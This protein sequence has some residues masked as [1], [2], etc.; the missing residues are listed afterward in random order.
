MI[1]SPRRRRL[2]VDTMA[3]RSLLETCKAWN[4][5]LGPQKDRMVAHDDLAIAERNITQDIATHT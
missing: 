1:Y 2:G 3:S 4:P 5:R